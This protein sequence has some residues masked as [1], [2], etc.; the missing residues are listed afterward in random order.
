LLQWFSGNLFIIAAGAILGPAAV[1]ATRMAQNIVGVTHV[2]FLAMENIIPA[3][4]AMQLRNNGPEGMMRYLLKFSWQ[5][6]AITV[7]VLALIATFSYTIIDFCYGSEYVAYQH[8]LIGFC[9]L[10]LIVFLGYPF[11]YAI[12]TL[13]RTRVIFVS[14]IASSVFSVATAYP[15]IRLFGI[16]GVVGGLM[17]TQL[18]TLWIYLYCLR[19]EL[20]KM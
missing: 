11:R 18:I 3:R 6:G 5:M 17:I 7:G 12:R 20:K 14:F 13:E 2:L 4:A 19:K 16:T 1:G 15:A 8:I 9:V 10:Y